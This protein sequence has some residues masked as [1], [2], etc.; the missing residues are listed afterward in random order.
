MAEHAGVDIGWM[1]AS[2]RT[3][4]RSADPDPTDGKEY[5]TLDRNGLRHISPV[6]RAR[7]GQDHLLHAAS[8]WI[9]HYPMRK[10]GIA[11]LDGHCLSDKPI[12]Q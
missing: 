3:E 1:A 7:S 8:N 9:N 4:I 5:V 11:I 2:E 6:K 12:Q 10:Y